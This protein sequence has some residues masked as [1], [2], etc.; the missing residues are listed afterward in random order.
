M[1]GHHVTNRQKSLFMQFHKTDPA[2]VAA[3][4]AGFSP[5]TAYRFEKDPPASLA[6][7]SATG[8]LAPSP[9]R[10]HLGER[11]LQLVDRRIDLFAEG[12]AIELVEHG[13]VETLDE[14]LS[15]SVS[16]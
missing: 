12:D 5:A 4:K 6:R 14:N 2:A 11:G 10:K 8:A 9:P 13:F 15:L 16:F 3:A 7:E 1:P